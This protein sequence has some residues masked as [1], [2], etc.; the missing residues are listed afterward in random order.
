[1]TPAELARRKIDPPLVQCGW[2]VQN[3]N[4]MNIST[5][6]GVAIRE[7]SML[8]GEADYLLY[9]AGKAIGVIEAKPEG[10]PLIG[11]E[12]Q[13]A[14]YAGAFP[15]GIPAHRRPLSFSYEST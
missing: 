10:H 9:C 1:V 4:E 6:A 15:E 11:V 13:S 14:K 2:I 5:G 3:R 7:L 8:T 12:T